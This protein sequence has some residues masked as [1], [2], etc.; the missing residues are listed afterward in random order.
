MCTLTHCFEFSLTRGSS[1]YRCRTLGL[2][3]D[4]QLISE[5]CTP[6]QHTGGVAKAGILKSINYV[7]VVFDSLMQRGNREPR[8]Q[9]RGSMVL[10]SDGYKAHSLPTGTAL[11]AQAGLLRLKAQDVYGESV[12]QARVHRNVVPQSWISHSFSFLSSFFSQRY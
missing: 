10:T 4:L 9:P 11:T 6:A 2:L 7:D 8:Y 1:Y 3:S 5:W 12:A